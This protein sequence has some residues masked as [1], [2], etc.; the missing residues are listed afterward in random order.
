MLMVMFCV[1]V[2]VG[3]VHGGVVSEV[4]ILCCGWDLEASLWQQ[5][6]CQVRLRNITKK[7]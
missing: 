3:G 5:A 1:C 4:C 7:D 6:W 2:H